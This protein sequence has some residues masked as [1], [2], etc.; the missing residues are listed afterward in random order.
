M[1][2]KLARPDKTVR[3]YIVELFQLVVKI[4]GNQKAHRC[5]VPEREATVRSAT[6][7]FSRQFRQ[8]IEPSQPSRRPRPPR[9]ARPGGSGPFDRVARPVTLKKTPS[10]LAR[11]AWSPEHGQEDLRPRRIEHRADRHPGV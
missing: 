9:I 3:R 10:A 2:C 7:A 8:T 4:R 6:L 11:R 5:T 1:V